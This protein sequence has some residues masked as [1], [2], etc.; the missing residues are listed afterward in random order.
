MDR[1]LNDITGFSALPPEAPLLM[2]TQSLRTPLPRRDPPLTGPRLI[3]L[4]RLLVIGGATALALE[5]TYQMY[6]VLAVNGPTPLA[7]IMIVLFLALFGWIALS[8]TSALAGFFSMLFGGGSRLLTRD[9]AIPVTR[10]ALLMPTY[11]EPPLRVMAGLQAIW[12]S[13]HAAG[14]A[15]ET[16]DLFILSDTTDADAW[17]AEE[18]AYLDLLDRTDGHGRIFYRHRRHN[19]AR[20]AG[21][22]A[23]WVTRFGGAWPQFLILD[24]DSVMDADTLIRLVNAMERHPNVG[25]IQTLPIIAGGT[26]LFSRLQ[27]FA[28]RVYGPLIAHGIAWWHG[29]EGNYWGHNAL[30]RT[31]AFAASAGLPEL[32]GRKPF[33]G[34][35]LSHDFVEAA[36]LRRAGWA[37]HMVPALR[38]SYEECPPTL[39]DLAIRDRRWCQGNLQHTAVLPA[40][41]LHWISRLHLL[42][43]IGSYITAPLWLLFLLCGIAIAVQARFVPPN[44][45]PAGRSLFPRWPVIDP[46]R[47]MWMFIGT[48]AVLLLPKLL[49]VLAIRRD[50][51]RGCG[52]LLRLV[53]SVLLETMLTGLIAPVVM[54]TQTL[55]VTTILFGRDSGWN[56]QRR[57]DGSVPFRV[58]AAEYRWHTMV[59]VA[60]GGIAWATSWPL[61]LWMSPV[62]LGLTLAIPLAAVTA[63]RG[64]GLALR[65]LGLLRIPEEANPPHV[66]ARAHALVRAGQDARAEQKSALLLLHDPVLLA[67]HLRMLS[68]ATPEKP[69]CVDIPL[70]VARAR[71]NAARAPAEAWDVMTP[72]ERL[73]C[74]ADSRCINWLVETEQSDVNACGA[75]SVLNKSPH[76]AGTVLQRRT[77][78]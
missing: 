3:G 32:S 30:I 1:P 11:N 36:L 2:P 20:K 72:A 13:L 37:V 39:T 64:A 71:L 75:A 23:D 63:R 65:R 38:G 55:H 70:A 7:I 66:L 74:L 48:M 77:S 68:P 15:G 59:G 56:A 47:A 16:F 53:T 67:G 45:F 26:T 31:Q 18:A 54:L 78:R 12:E 35:I 17:I 33:R 52:G 40:R 25:L 73:A 9:L 34:L 60:L 14:A 6:R 57:D 8:F 76:T 22:I 46:V 58:T 49:G 4:R 62:V 43:G 61:A 21:N 19:S 50:D 5:G 69:D 41:G 42:T 10:T 44:Y 24:A 51:R 29:A 27:Q 28:G